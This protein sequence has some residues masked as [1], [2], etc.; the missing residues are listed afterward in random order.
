VF[1]NR[2][3]ENGRKHLIFAEYDR[4][5]SQEFWK[6]HAPVMT[7]EQHKFNDL[8][9]KVNGIEKDV[10]Q[11]KDDVYKQMREIKKDLIKAVRDREMTLD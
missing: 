3:E 2:N 8:D 1:W 11:M 4:G 7:E 9:G 6:P 5:N 10:K